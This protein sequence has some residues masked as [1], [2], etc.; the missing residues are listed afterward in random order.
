MSRALKLA[1]NAQSDQDVQ[2]EL[3]NRLLILREIAR[4][5]VAEPEPERVSSRRKD[6][7]ACWPA[8]TDVAAMLSKNG[9]SEQALD[10]WCRDDVRIAAYLEQRFGASSDD[11]REARIAS[12]IRDLRQRANL[13][14]R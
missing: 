11:G 8:G 6:W 7:T 5:T 13:P 3:E 1:G 9:M 4:A 10:G 14:A 2:T 12:W